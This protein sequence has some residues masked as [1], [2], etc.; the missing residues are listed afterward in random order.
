MIRKQVRLIGNIFIRLFILL[1]SFQAFA[2]ENII[3]L[4]SENWNILG[5]EVLEYSGRT[6]FYGTAILKD[7]EFRN[8]IIEY[9]INVTGGRSYPG[10]I[11]RIQPGAQGNYENIYIRPHRSGL[12]P[13]AVQ[14]TAAFN[15]IAEW[16]LCHGDGYTALAAFPENEWF[17]VKIEVKRTQARVF[18]EASDNPA[19]V[20]HDLKHGDLSGGVALS[21]PANKTAYFS[22]FRITH[23][24]ELEFD[25]PPEKSAPEG[26]ITHWEIS[27]AF[28]VSQIRKDNY[29][30]FFM[31]F[32]A[33]WESIPVEPSGILNIGRHRKRIKPPEA[34]CVLVR[35]SIYSETKRNVKLSL[36][37]SDEV[38]LFLNS[39][40]IFSANSSY[41]SRDRSFVGVIGFND[42][43][44]LPLE[45]GNNEILMYITERFGGWGVMAKLDREVD[46]PMKDYDLLQKEW[47]TPNE[48]LTPESVVY[49]GEREVLYVT[50]YD[51]PSAMLG[52]FDDNTGYISKVKL[53]G[54]IEEKEWVKDLHFPAG[55]CIHKDRIYTLERRNLVE[56]DIYNGRIVKRYPL[57]EMEFANDIAADVEGNIYISNTSNP[58]LA[59]DIYKF[60][61]GEFEVWLDGEEIHRSNGIY[62]HGGELLVGNSG[63]G[64][65]KAINLITKKVRKIACVGGGV[66]DGIRIDN[67]GNYLVS[68]WGGQIFRITP[69]GEVV[70]IL[71][72]FPGKF[73]TADFEYIAAKNLMIIP[74]FTADKLICYKFIS[75]R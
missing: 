5:G 36:G 74:T 11:F 56:I 61:N 9:D 71:N 25:A 53:N 21:A 52:K 29:P 10:I 48:L 43:L 68:K 19:L 1:L 20:I 30:S 70:E 67:N 60:R 73:N 28:P 2:Q 6:A 33:G 42:H 62:I 57:P 35:S 54:E 34:D 63:D 7:V 15:G 44:I 66:I 45:K 47:E 65:L 38:D 13:D 55:M 40:K 37:Y 59:P 64:I 41:Q 24:D 32:N 31:S 4:N 69:E 72:G 26:I 12:Y 14:Y 39:R 22:N 3:E 49:D 18:L 46:I 8:G 16:Q 50:N 23:T 58:L 17:H 51:F 27:K 75:K